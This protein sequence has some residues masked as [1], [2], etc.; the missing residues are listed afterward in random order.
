MT[1]M[2]RDLRGY[3]FPHFSFE[4]PIDEKCVFYYNIINTGLKKLSVSQP[5]FEKIFENSLE[6]IQPTDK[7]KEDIIKKILP[8]ERITLNAKDGTRFSLIQFTPPTGNWYQLCNSFCNL[9]ISNEYT[10]YGA[11]IQAV[12]VGRPNHEVI[13]TALNKGGCGLA[14]LM[15]LGILTFDDYRVAFSCPEITESKIGINTST[16]I[17]LLDNNLPEIDIRSLIC[18]ETFIMYNDKDTEVFKRMEDYLQANLNENCA[19]LLRF[20]DYRGG[21]LDERQFGH[22]IIVYKVYNKLFFFDAWRATVLTFKQKNTLKPDVSSI[23]ASPH[24]FSYDEFNLKKIARVMASVNHTYNIIFQLFELNGRE[25]IKPFEPFESPFHRNTEW[26]VIK[27]LRKVIDAKRNTH[28]LVKS[29]AQNWKSVTQQ[30]KIKE[31]VINEEGVKGFELITDTDTD[32][33]TNTD[34][35]NVCIYVVFGEEVINGGNKT[36]KNRSK[37]NKTRKN[38][39]KPRQN[40]NKN[41]TRKSKR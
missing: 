21:V 39:N 35:D 16:L 4:P 2:D 8:E 23:Y 13:N 36:R 40:K 31:V 33:D 12:T 30:K 34:T 17:T 10:Y 3:Y 24:F 20:G 26:D 15:A 11:N 25:I 27:K 18:A 6:I 14:A 37:K 32:T 28:N 29:I 1:E 5:D 41:K 19:T 9:R 38:K 22:V 7:E